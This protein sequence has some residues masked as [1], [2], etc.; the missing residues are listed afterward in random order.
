M[1]IGKA[2]RGVKQEGGEERKERGGYVEMRSSTLDGRWRATS[3]TRFFFSSVV[4]SVGI[5]EVVDSAGGPAYTIGEERVQS[6]AAC[7]L[8]G[9]AAPAEWRRW[10]QQCA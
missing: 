9:A 6:D 5:R 7:A 3:A 4:E 2:A 1:G 8:E 10:C